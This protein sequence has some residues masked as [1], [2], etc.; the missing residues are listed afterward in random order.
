M[1]IEKA[2]YV[3]EDIK[4][5]GIDAGHYEAEDAIELGIEA[6][7][8]IQRERN[9]LATTKPLPLPGEDAI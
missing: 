9:Y 4:D 5:S 7:K 2:I 1:K 8:R 6:L 3:L